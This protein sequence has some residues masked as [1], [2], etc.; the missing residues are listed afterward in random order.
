MSRRSKGQSSLVSIGLFTTIVVAGVGTLV[1]FGTPA[2]NNIAD[3]Q[4]FDT[5]GD[6][7]TDIGEN[8]RAVAEGGT[9]TSVEIG[10]EFPRG[11]L[12][13]DAEDDEVTYQ[14]DSAADIISPHSTRQV[15]DL[16]ISALAAASVRL[17]R[18]RG[19]D[20]LMLRNEHIEACIRHIPRQPGEAIGNR[21]AGFW[22]FNER[23]GDTAADNA[24]GNTATLGSGGEAPSWTDGK[25]GGGLTFDGSDD[26]A[27]V[28]HD[29]V[30]NTDGVTVTAWIRPDTVT[31]SDQVIMHKGTSTSDL[32]T[33]AFQYDLRTAGDGTLV[34][35]VNH[36]GA[37][38]AAVSG[39]DLRDA[40]DEWTFVAATANA[41]HLTLRRGDDVLAT[42]TVPDDLSATDDPL[43]FGDAGDDAAV[44]D[45]AIDEV[46]IWDRALTPAHLDWL[47]TT[48]GLLDYI[49]TR[50]LLL[51]Y[52]N[53]D[54]DRN[55]SADFSFKLHSGLERG[56]S[57]NGT[58]YTAASI[59]GDNLG[60]GIVTARVRSFLGLDYK[61]E[62]RV[63]SGSDFVHVNP[64]RN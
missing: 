64:V 30:L 13:F 3:A 19:Q 28:S 1:A 36:A 46:R 14:I 4:A 45:G 27:T 43:R 49:D 9:G 23:Q 29:P 61:L 52:R 47:E 34:W 33:E 57:Q 63:L 58:G 31:G 51:H 39:G 53:R 11:E 35:T 41:T 21:T 6:L 54:T 5:A 12:A 32:S 8:I 50:H 2:I 56:F 48:E 16:T 24:S 62:F 10:V 60:D 20:C 26:H 44:W 59:T 18:I 15:G 17:T 37:G 25:V 22:R 42:G 7:L 38:T 40:T 55:L